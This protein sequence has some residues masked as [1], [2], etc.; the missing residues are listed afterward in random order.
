MGALAPFY[1]M[2]KADRYKHGDYNAI[3]DQCG[4]K[5]KASQ[6]QMTWDGFFVCEKCWEPRH[7]QDFVRAKVDKQRIAIARPDTDIQFQLTY[8]AAAESAGDSSINIDSISYVLED[9]PLLIMMDGPFSSS[10]HSC[11]VTE[12]PA[13]STNVLIDP[14]LTYAAASGNNVYVLNGSDYLTATEVS[15]DDL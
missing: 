9:T 14:P 11:L 4:F 12:T 15:A 6:L 8:L 7:P 3:C 5:F 1:S 13:V 2:G 10:Y